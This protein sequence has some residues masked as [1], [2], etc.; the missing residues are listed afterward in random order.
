MNSPA[1]TATPDQIQAA[2]DLYASDEIQIDDDAT[3][4]PAPH[5][6]SFGYWVQAWVWVPA[7][8]ESR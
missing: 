3:V 6:P 2:R 7:D 8:E 4:S 1:Q 5:N